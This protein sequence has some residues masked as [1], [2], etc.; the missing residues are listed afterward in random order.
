[1]QHL[2]AQ[3]LGL[4]DIVTRIQEHN[5][6]HHEAHSASLSRLASDVKTSYDGIGDHFETSFQ[7][8]EELDSDMAERAA[9]LQETL[10]ALDAKSEIRQPLAEL[11]AD[12][13]ADA[14]EEYKIT[15]ETPQRIQYSY[16]HNLPRTEQ[17]ET[18]L[19]KLHGSPLESPSKRSPTKQQIFT[20]SS[21]SSSTRPGSSARPTTP[22]LREVDVNILAAPADLPPFPDKQK[23]EDTLGVLMPPLKRQNTLVG[24]GGDS[25]LP[26]KRSKRMTVAGSAAE[27]LASAERENLTVDLSRSVGAGAMHPGG[28][29][30]LRSHN[31]G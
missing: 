26:K 25:K 5:N 8:I 9:A 11:R 28:G 3:L 12:I 2:D 23:G 16:P 14:L 1:M 29:R 17:H 27:K 10:P 6:S 15:G 13:E 31:S 4:D 22:G 19:A 7:R 18:L 20:D 30:R 21:D 24:A